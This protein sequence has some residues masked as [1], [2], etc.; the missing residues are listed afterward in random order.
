MY[1][2]LTFEFSA[3]E[4]KPSDQNGKSGQVIS[5]AAEPDT[6]ADDQNEPKETE[7]TPDVSKE[8]EPEPEA[9]PAQ[10]A[11]KESA[12][13]PEKIEEAEPEKADEPF[14]MVEKEDL[15]EEES[16]S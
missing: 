4:A 11:E 8:P 2:C 6:L 14:E 7:P 9:E 16:V 1:K 10:E 12:S 15:P 13:E 5:S 3:S